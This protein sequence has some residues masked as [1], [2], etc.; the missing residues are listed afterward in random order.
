[1]AASFFVRERAMDGAQAQ[2][3]QQELIGATLDGWTIT[4]SLGH[5]KSAVVMVGE[6]AGESAAVKVFHP[7]LVERFGRDTQL[8]RIRREVSLVGSAHPHV[9]NILGGGEADSG[10]LYVAMEMLPWKNLK[11]ALAQ[12][13]TD[14]VPLLIA[15]L[16]SAARFLEDKGLAHRDIKPEN[17]AISDDFLTLKLLDLGVVRPFGAAGLTDVDSRSFI[18]TLRYSSPEFLRREEVDSIDGWR[19]L[20]FYQVGAVLHDLIMRKELFEEC[21]EPYAILVEAVHER[22][23]IVAGEDL[24]LVR[25]CKNC[26]LKDPRARLALVNWE[27]FEAES[28][29]SDERAKLFHQIRNRQGYYSQQSSGTAGIPLH[30]EEQRVHREEIRRASSSLSFKIGKLLTTLK[31]FP[32]HSLS[33]NVDLRKDEATC[34]VS[35][36]KDE[37]LGLTSSIEMIFILTCISRSAGALVFELGAHAEVGGNSL[38]ERAVLCAGTIDEVLPDRELEGWML[39]MLTKAYDYIEARNF[40]G[41]GEE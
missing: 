24:R 39:S 38:G 35:F 7:E 13:P 34:G 10:W 6:K 9:V 25:L 27:S 17:I 26:L 5:G 40:S 37:S 8:E 15:Q 14:A 41:G 20:T 32:L 4:G 36:L 2:I 18:G 12:V 22:N 29:A 19:A 3:L 21:S 30:S 11:E 16:S 23:P 33:A 31:C 28:S 1:M